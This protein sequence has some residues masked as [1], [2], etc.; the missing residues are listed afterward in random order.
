MKKNHP[1]SLHGAPFFFC[2]TIFFAN[3]T[4]IL[5]FARNLLLLEYFYR[6]NEFNSETMEFMELENGKVML[7]FNPN[8]KQDFEFD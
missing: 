2:Q 7:V 6:H 1:K 4:C 5:I 8:A 3:L